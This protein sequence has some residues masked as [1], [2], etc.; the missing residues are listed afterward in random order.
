MSILAWEELGRKEGYF[1][2]ARKL[3]ERHSLGRAGSRRRDNVGGLR[4]GEQRCTSLVV[5]QVWSQHEG[6]RAPGYR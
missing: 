1:V 3:K 2:S 6:E 5:I 4:A